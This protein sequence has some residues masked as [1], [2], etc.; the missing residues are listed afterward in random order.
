MGFSA[1]SYYLIAFVLE[2]T[3]EV[4]LKVSSLGSYTGTSI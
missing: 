1:L 2:V 3:I 4:I